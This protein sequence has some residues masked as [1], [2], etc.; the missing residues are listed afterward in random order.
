MPGALPTLRGAERDA[1]F[2]LSWVPDRI[3]PSCLACGKGFSAVSPKPHCSHAH[4]L[5]GPAIALPRLFEG[6]PSRTTHTQLGFAQIVWRHHCR[7]CGRVFCESCTGCKQVSECAQW[8][9]RCLRLGLGFALAWLGLAW[10]GL[11]WLGLAWLGLA[12]PGL[13]WLGLA[14]LGLAWL[15][16]AWLGLAWLGLAWRLASPLLVYLPPGLCA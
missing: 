15:G 4:S 8:A 10:L 1:G 11:A 5:V 2:K 13:A 6:R 14:W 16:L 9:M 7:F 3:V 12:W